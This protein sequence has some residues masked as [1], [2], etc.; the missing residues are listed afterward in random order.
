MGVVWVLLGSRVGAMWVQCGT[1][2]KQYGSSVE[3]IWKQCGSI[4]SAVIK[5]GDKVVMCKNSLQG[6]GCF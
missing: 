3:A 6:E 2:W 5:P 1:V 4:V